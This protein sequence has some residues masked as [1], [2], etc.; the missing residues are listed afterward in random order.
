DE[1]IDVRITDET[2]PFKLSEMEFAENDVRLDI[3]WQERCDAV[4]DY[5]E[6]RLAHHGRNNWTK[7][8]TAK[9]LNVSEAT[10]SEYIGITELVRE[11]YT[12]LKKQPER[13]NAITMMSKINK[14]RKAADDEEMT[15]LLGEEILGRKISA[16]SEIPIIPADFTEW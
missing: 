1:F 5:H 11:G 7:K 13:S 8:Q 14:R 6:K 10:V 4:A 2:D 16:K 15:E 12:E 9:R 3:T